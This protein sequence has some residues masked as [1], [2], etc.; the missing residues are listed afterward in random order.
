MPNGRIAAFYPLNAHRIELDVAAG[1]G[2]AAFSSRKY[3]IPSVL[4]SRLAVDCGYQGQGIGALTLADALGVCAT[5][6]EEIGVEVVVV[7]AIDPGAAAFYQLH[8]FA[9]L[10]ADG[11]RL[12]VTTK[13]VRAGR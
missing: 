8:G 10:T 11:R 6:S 2:A 4:I 12:Y 1:V 3:P 13:H 5:V 7:D 9:R